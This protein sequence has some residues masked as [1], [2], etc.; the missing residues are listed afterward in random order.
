MIDITVYKVVMMVNDSWVFVL[1]LLI[2]NINESLHL[3][4]VLIGKALWDINKSDF[5]VTD[6]E[7]SY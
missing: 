2:V 6:S 4:W 5:I 7:R 3:V 1:W